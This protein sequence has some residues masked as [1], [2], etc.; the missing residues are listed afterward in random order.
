MNATRSI[1]AGTAL[2]AAALVMSWPSPAVA[3]ESLADGCH[4][5]AWLTDDIADVGN[6]ARRYRKSGQIKIVALGSSSTLGSG[7][8]GPAAAWPARLQ[9]EL[10]RRLPKAQVSVIN[11]GKM[12]QSAQEMVERMA[13]DVE[14]ERPDLVIWEA[15]TAEAVR[16]IEVDQLTHRLFEGVDRLT[17]RGIDVILMDMQYARSTARVINFERYVEAMSQV[18]TIRNIYV[19]QRFA[20]MR[21]WV[22]DKHVSFDDQTP[23]EAIRGADRVYSCIATFLSEVIVRSM[24]R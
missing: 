3:R 16:A 19:F 12:R 8:S 21:R 13:S 4:E 11:R 20:L 5:P 2:L 14:S 1:L 24:A 18:G 23:A 7:G 10:A 17:Q 9:D 22:E 6:M 15:G